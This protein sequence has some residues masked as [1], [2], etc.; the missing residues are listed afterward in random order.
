MITSFVFATFVLAVSGNS[1]TYIN[2]NVGAYAPSLPF[3]N[4]QFKIKLRGEQT[5]HEVGVVEVEILHGS[6]GNHLHTREDE[7]FNVLEG[8]V[9]FF[10]NGTQFCAKTGDYIYIPRYVSQTFRVN[11]PTF[12]KKRVRLEIVMFPGGGEGFFE[13][14]AIYFIQGQTNNSTIADKI[15]KKYGFV[16]LEPVEWEDIGCFNDN[17]N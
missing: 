14:M 16:F 10:V 9:Q 2:R 11:N 15:G 17:N 8:Q 7:Y 1:W 6:P 5:S 13:D 3:P 12:T 4:S